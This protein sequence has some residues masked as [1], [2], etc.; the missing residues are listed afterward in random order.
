[1]SWISEQAIVETVGIGAGVR[2]AEFSV[3]R[4]G[5]TIGDAVVIHPH[6]VI[7]SG[8]TIGDN[9]EIF[10]GAY[11]GKV[12]KGAGALTRAPTFVAGSKS[13]PIA[14]SGHTL[15]SSTMSWLAHQP[16][17]AM[18]RRSVNKPGSVREL[19]LGVT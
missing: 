2:I 1:M 17:W 11:I 12:P 14:L 19:S 7:E 4:A 10:P 15:S 13:G 6:V 3:I 5:V 9:V 8:V 16:C 18:G